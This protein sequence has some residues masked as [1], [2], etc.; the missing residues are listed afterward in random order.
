[1]MAAVRA[2]LDKERSHSS[3][4]RLHTASQGRR[5]EINIAPQPAPISPQS[6]PRAQVRPPSASSHSQP[7]IQAPSTSPTIAF[8]DTTFRYYAERCSTELANLRSVCTRAILKEKQDKEKWRSHCVTFKQ[9]RDVARE[10]V[11]A[12]IGEREAHLLPLPTHSEDQNKDGASAEADGKAISESSRSV[13]SRES[14][15]S[16]TAV[17][18]DPEDDLSLYLLPYP[19]PPPP[20][21]STLKRSRSADPALP[22]SA[23]KRDTTGFDIT[24]H[25][26][27][28][29]GV[30]IESERAMKRRRGEGSTLEPVASPTRRSNADV[31]GLGE[32][33]MELESEADA[34]ET[35]PKDGDKEAP[36]PKLKSKSKS[37][38]PRG[39]PSIRPKAIQ[40]PTSG[41]ELSHVDLMYVPTNGKLVCRVCL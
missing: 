30:W 18:S 11:R 24:V 9:E 38:S 6:A 1:M 17:A 8:F 15:P 26:N 2:Q 39:S 37:K 19:S 20:P 33:D 3:Q 34:S 28:H 10:R 13:P 31:N 25:E 16:S 32:C 29:G 22:S 40:K 23:F 27:P 14:T 36:K 5:S 7:R 41:I 21:S 12:L 4:P 35:K